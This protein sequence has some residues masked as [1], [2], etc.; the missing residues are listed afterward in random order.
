M[1][2]KNI[3]TIFG[4]KNTVPGVFELKL[5]KGT[6]IPF[7]QVYDHQVAALLAVE[8]TG[9]YHKIQDDP[10]SWGNRRFSR[11]KP[12]D[13]FLLRGIPAYVVVVFYVPR[14]RKTAYYIRI[15]AFVQ[16][17][18]AASRESMTEAMA[19]DCAQH[20]VELS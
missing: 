3:Q 9:F 7:K 14:K 20:V 6:S 2:E 10:V 17:R 12:F 4:K 5:C 1:K 15:S 19:R 11:S 13:C 16:A 8:Q 18:M